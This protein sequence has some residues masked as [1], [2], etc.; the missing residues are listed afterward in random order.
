MRSLRSIFCASASIVLAFWIAGCAGPNSSKPQAQSQ[1]IATLIAAPPETRWSAAGPLI[2]HV[3]VR[4]AEISAV[5]AWPDDERRYDGKL[6]SDHA[7]VE[8]DLKVDI[9][10][11][12]S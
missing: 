8:V 6:L 5:R 12:Q 3:L 11:K 4:G 7:P 2:D 10:L 1:T 9:G